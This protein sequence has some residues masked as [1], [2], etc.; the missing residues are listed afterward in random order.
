ML[1]GVLQ[2]SVLWR[3]FFLIYINDLSKHFYSNTILFADDTSI[4]P[5]VKN[6]SLSREQLNSDLEKISN[7]AHQWKMS[8]NPDPKPQA[9]E[10]VF[11]RKRVRLSS[12]SFFN[13]TI[14]ERSASQKHLGIHLDE[15]LDFNT[16]IEGKISKAYRGIGIIKKL[17]SKLS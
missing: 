5:T 16:H 13:D 8:L 4:F 9:E 15:Q 11:S 10:V 12:I 17:Q 2:G 14:V 6:V 7:W 3:L 1:A